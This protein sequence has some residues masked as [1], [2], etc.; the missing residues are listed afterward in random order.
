MKIIRKIKAYFKKIKKLG[1][2]ANI[3]ISAKCKKTVK[4][5]EYNKIHRNWLIELLYFKCN[6]WKLKKK[7]IKQNKKQKK[8]LKKNKSIRW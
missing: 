3:I 4:L 1:R 6:K 7:L 5:L 2:I 8:L